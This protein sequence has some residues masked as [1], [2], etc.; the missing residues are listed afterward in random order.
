MNVAEKLS[1]E[2]ARVTELRE[3]YKSVAGLPG[4]NCAPVLA[5]ISAALDRAHRAA[6]VDDAL[7][8]IAAVKEL[9]GFT[10]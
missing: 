10:G 8:Q 4:V 3:Q 5:M 6:G 2:I 9:E 1:R 7:G